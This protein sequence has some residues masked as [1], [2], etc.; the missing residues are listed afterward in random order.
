LAILKGGFADLGTVDKGAVGRAKIPDQD[1]GTVDD[2]LT[3]GTGNRG[4]CD[5]KIVGKAA[6]QEVV[7]RLEIN[8]PGSWRT[9]TDYESRHTRFDLC[10]ARM[11]EE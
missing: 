10:N 6:P 1:C 3:V 5:D 7:A 11:M 8:C 9:W 2:D 4:V